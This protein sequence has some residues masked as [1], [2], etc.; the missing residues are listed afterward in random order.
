MTAMVDKDSFRELLDASSLGDPESRAI[1]DRFE[2]WSR[3][4]PDQ[5]MRKTDLPTLLALY[6]DRREIYGENHPTAVLRVLGEVDY[7]PSQDDMD[8]IVE[9][10]CH[11]W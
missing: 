6:R 8:A 3:A 9:D 1:I 11:A 10:D 7:E 4:L 5:W 2:R